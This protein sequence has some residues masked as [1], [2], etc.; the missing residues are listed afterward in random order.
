[1]AL[2]GISVTLINV[3]QHDEPVSVAPRMHPGYLFAHIRQR[4]ETAHVRRRRKKRFWKKGGE[5]D[6]RVGEEDRN[7]SRTL[8]ADLLSPPAL[9]SLVGMLTA[10]ASFSFH[11]GSF[12]HNHSGQLSQHR[13]TLTLTCF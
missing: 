3:S 12:R 6:E 2:L 11:L 4:K 13:P 5:K 8:G 9:S 10:N 7:R 1:M